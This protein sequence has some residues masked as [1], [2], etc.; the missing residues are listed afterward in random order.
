MKKIFTY[1]SVLLS[2]ALMGSVTSCDLLNPASELTDPGLGIKVFFPT[3][4]VAGQPMTI[5]GSGFTGV[6][7]IVFPNGVSVTDFEIVSKDMIRVTAPAGIA[8]GGGNLLVRT[9]DDQAESRVP[10][11]L[12]KTVVSGFS[13]QEGETIK[14]GELLTI[15]GTDLEFINRVE[16]VDEAGNPLV[17]SEDVFYRKGTS[18]VVIKIP[19]GVLLDAFAGKFTT[20]DGQEMALPML[21]YEKGSDEGHW[22]TQKHVFW[23]NDGSK[24]TVDWGNVNYRFGLDGK[25]GNNECIA[26]FPQEIWDQI[27]TGTFY[28]LFKIDNPDWYQVRVTNGHWTVQWQGAENDFSPN[29][30]ADKVIDNGDGTYYIE[31]N[32]GD[33]PIVETL[34]DKHLLFTGSGYTVLELYYTEDIWIDGGEGHSEIVRTYFWENN[35]DKGTVDWGNVNYRFGLDGKDGNNECIATFPQEI[36][37]QIKTGTFYMLF[38]IDNPDWYQVRVTNGHWTVQW[39]G[40]ENDFSPNN[41]ADKVIDNGDG[42]YYIEINFG[43]DPIV[44]TL[45]DKH[46]LFTG[47]GYTPLALYSEEEIW[48]DGGGDDDEPAEIDI[49]PFTYYEDRSATLTYPYHPSWSDNSGKLR[50]MRGGDPAI[51]SLGLTT[52]SKFIVYKEAGTTG[53]I[54]FNNPNWQAFEVGCADWE[55]TAETIEIP[56]TEAMLACINGE[57]ADGWSDTAIILQGDGMTVNKIVIVK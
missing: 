3:K 2:L 23:S 47:S 17:L 8:A 50:I 49:A 51:E 41:M 7:E 55:G 43:D 30:M 14:E 42:T 32:F 15:Y 6:S 13:K 46:L 16:L 10:L 28:M 18:S 25:D 57:V 26:T 5:N 44:E 52:S 9:A 29:N 34:D 24:G 45:D 54:Q 37:D 38:K 35:S 4:V 40:A 22:E 56:I 20:Y 11:T 27:K 21:T 39:Q 33:D 19:K 31:I 48:I 53:Q 36:W 1:L 12:G